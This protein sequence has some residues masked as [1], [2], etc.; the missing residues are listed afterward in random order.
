MY[1]VFGAD[2]SGMNDTSFLRLFIVL[3]LLAL[4]S[5]ARAQSTGLR[6]HVG[7]DGY[8]PLA[9]TTTLFGRTMSP[10]WAQQALD[11]YAAKGEAPP[12]YTI[13]L[14]KE[15]Y[16]VY[17]P[18]AAPPE[19]G[20]GLLVFVPPWPNAA[21]PRSWRGVLDE[22][23]VI[24]ATAANSGNEAPEIPR[25]MALALH[26]YANVSRQFHVDPD[27]VYVGGFSGGGRVA[28]R[29]AL[30]Y[31]DVFRGALID[32]AGDD[33]GSFLVPLPEATLLQ[34]VQERSRLVYMHGTED[35]PNAMRVRYSMASARELCIFDATKLSIYRRG[36]EPADAVTWGR[37]LGLL[38]QP[39]VEP[40][41]ELGECRARVDAEV[42]AGIAH[43]RELFAHGNASD[44]RKA[45]AA[46]D[47]RFAHL[48]APATLELSK[49]LPPR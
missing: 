21:V 39:A 47:A 9:K 8:S 11:A 40:S 45:L 10:L 12:N 44:A 1:P 5:P 19:R 33:I 14:G 41:K 35:E 36:H 23:G 49:Q 15:S 25:R 27:R 43:V 3:T 48:A 37:G 2:G 7:F 32:G 16:S 31:P 26:E 38:E 34:R 28:L 22:H 18:E 6:E 29:L 20:Y 46:L 30:G 24:F 13:D 42:A 4:A 17:V